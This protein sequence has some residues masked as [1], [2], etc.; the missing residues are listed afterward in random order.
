MKAPLAGLMLQG[1]LLGGENSFVGA[2]EITCLISMRV[3]Q[4]APQIY[5]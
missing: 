5:A 2:R 3:H 4:T 1:I